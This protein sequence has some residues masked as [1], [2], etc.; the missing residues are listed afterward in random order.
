MIG[1]Y[2]WPSI[3]HPL[4]SVA[5]VEQM[6]ARAEQATP[7]PW[8]LVGGEIVQ[9]F[10]DAIGRRVNRKNTLIVGTE[11][12][13]CHSDEP[14]CGCCDLLVLKSVDAEFI[15]SARTD[16]PRLAEAYLALRERY[17]AGTDAELL[18]VKS[19]VAQLTEEREALRKQVI[20]EAILVL[21]QTN[22]VAVVRSLPQLTFDDCISLLEQFKAT[23]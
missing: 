9:P 2:T 15:T 20:T 18:A 19:T 22:N 11:L 10:H 16:L 7:G 1:P 8:E 13:Q 14:C 5:E 23:T 21:A 17:I 4:L 6:R 12:D 3:H